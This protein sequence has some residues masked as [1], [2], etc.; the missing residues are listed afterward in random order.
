ITAAPGLQRQVFYV[1]VDANNIPAGLYVTGFQVNCISCDIR[2]CKTIKPL[3]GS[4]RNRSPCSRRE[5]DDHQRRNPNRFQCRKARQ[6][7]E[8]K[9]KKGPQAAQVV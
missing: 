2:T 9:E 6:A 5:K 8:G 3:L 7:K 1:R 4:R